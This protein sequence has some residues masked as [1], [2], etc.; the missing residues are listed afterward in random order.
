MVVQCSGHCFVKF[1]Y[2]AEIEKTVL[3]DDVET[4]LRFVLFITRSYWRAVLK[5]I[6]CAGSFIT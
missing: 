3:E 4:F 1:L 5:F 2:T 6:V